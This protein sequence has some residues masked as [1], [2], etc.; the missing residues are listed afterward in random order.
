MSK[1]HKKTGSVCLICDE[2]I[3]SKS[4]LLHKTTRQTHRLCQDCSIGYFKPILQQACNNIRK[5]IRKG[6][7]NIKCPGSYH[8]KPRNQCKHMISIHDIIVPDNSPISLDVF[9]LSYVI[10]NPCCYLCPEEKCGEIIVIDEQYNGSYLQC[11]ACNTNWC[12]HCLAQPYHT[13]K[14]CIEFEATNTNSENGK[15]I[16]DMKSKGLLKFCPR[17]RTPICKHNGCNKII[18]TSCAVKWCWLCSS[19]E[20][21]YDHYNPANVIGCSGKLWEGV[22]KHGNQIQ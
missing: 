22:D 16:L 17:C 9:R 3:D 1:I 5:N 6:I 11:G 8:C 4:V 15:L 12:C 18:C 13:G 21:D 19:S 10:D 20:I 2:N 7:G 14:S